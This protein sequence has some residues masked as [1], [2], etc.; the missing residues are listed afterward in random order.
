MKARRGRPPNPQGRKKSLTIRIEAVLLG[1]LRKQARKHQLTLSQEVQDRL[2]ESLDLPVGL[3]QRVARL[4]R[5]MLPK[6][7]KA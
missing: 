6:A 3:E 4:E 7:V 1:A 2:G 5:L